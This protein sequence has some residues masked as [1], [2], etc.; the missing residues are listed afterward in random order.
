MRSCR[1]RISTLLKQCGIIST[2]T[3]QKAVKIQR[4]A[5]DV[6]HEALITIS[7]DYFQ[8]LQACLREFMLCLRI[9]VGIKYSRSGFSEF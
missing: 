3:E 4:R 8:E 6:L 7:K 9:K 1:A 2:R 5:S